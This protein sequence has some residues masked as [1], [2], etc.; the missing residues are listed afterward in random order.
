MGAQAG[1][2]NFN[3]YSRCTV[4]P[5]E[6]VINENYFKIQ[7][8]ETD[9]SANLEIYKNITKNPFNKKLEYFLGI[10]TKSKYDGVGRKL[11]EIDISIALDISGSMNSRIEQKETFK[12]LALKN[13]NENENQ[14]N[15]NI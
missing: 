3:P 12:E 4:I 5:Y 10:L 13:E 9:L 2:G 11:D 14:D 6:G 15:N 1:G 8:K 7:Q